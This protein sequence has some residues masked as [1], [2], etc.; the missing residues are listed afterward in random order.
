M[1]RRPFYA[2][3]LPSVIVAALFGVVVACVLASLHA[4]R[5]MDAIPEI[6]RATTRA[7]RD[8]A[9]REYLEEMAATEAARARRAPFTMPEP[10]PENSP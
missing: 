8:A 9:D 7:E 1:P 5:E 6:G 2:V 10:R 4:R 3:D